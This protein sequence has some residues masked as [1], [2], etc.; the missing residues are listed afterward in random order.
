MTRINIEVARAMVAAFDRGEVSAL[1]VAGL[2]PGL[3]AEVTELRAAEAVTFDQAIASRD[4]ANEVDGLDQVELVR[5]GFDIA[6]ASGA[7]APSSA[8]NPDEVE[9]LRSIRA[10]C[11]ERRVAWDPGWDECLA[12]LDKLLAAHGTKP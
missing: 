3:L 1:V 8:L 9:T 2:V 10:D 12:V 6:R 11:S 4:M 7:H 5:L